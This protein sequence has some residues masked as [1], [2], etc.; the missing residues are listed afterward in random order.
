MMNLED[1]PEVHEIVLKI[2]AEFNY[3]VASTQSIEEGEGTLLDHCAIIGTSEISFGRTH[4]LEDMPLLTAGSAGGTL[5]QGLH[6]HAP[7]ENASRFMMTIIQSLGLSIPSL[8]TTR[9]APPPG[10]LASLFKSR[11]HSMSW[12]D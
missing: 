3:L 10:F 7:G 1:Q 12:S 6:H 5:K 4:S 9:H 2:M 11:G 8:D